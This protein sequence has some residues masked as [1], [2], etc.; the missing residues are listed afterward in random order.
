MVDLS[1]TSHSQR[2]RSDSDE[3]ETQNQKLGRSRPSD[4]YPSPVSK[5][6]PQA[7]RKPASAV[8]TQTGKQNHTTTFQCQ[9]PGHT[10]LQLTLGTLPYSTTP[11][12][13][14]LIPPTPTRRSWLPCVWCEI[15]TTLKCLRT[16]PLMLPLWLLM[17]A[18]HWC[19]V[20]WS[21]WLASCLLA[22]FLVLDALVLRWMSLILS[23]SDSIL[24]DVSLWRKYR[25]IAAV[26]SC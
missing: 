12:P 18:A 4:K 14:H 17:A 22:A 11:P 7:I 1:C 10:R 15:E 25:T 21:C 13:I 16:S 23:I 6:N 2:V 3:T 26:S 9:G 20:S 5:R 24:Y 19:E 8:R